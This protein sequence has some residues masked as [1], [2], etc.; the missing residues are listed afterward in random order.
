ML[1]SGVLRALASTATAPKKLK[2][3]MESFVV[4]I[5]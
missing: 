2:N 4:L 5:A 1:A 3:M